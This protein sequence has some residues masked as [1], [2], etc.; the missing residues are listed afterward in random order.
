MIGLKKTLNTASVLGTRIVPR[1]DEFGCDI[2]PGAFLDQFWISF[3]QFR[4]CYARK[5]HQN[6]EIFAEI[7][8]CQ[9]KKVPDANDS[10]ES[11]FLEDFRKM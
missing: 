9:I 7:E 11:Q 6:C 3:G 1:I 8:K 2:A 10:L 5:F 4:V